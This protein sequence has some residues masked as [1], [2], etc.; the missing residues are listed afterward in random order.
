MTSTQVKTS[1]KKQGP[2]TGNKG[3]PSKREAFLNAKESSSSDKVYLAKNGKL[4]HLSHVVDLLPLKHS[5]LLKDFTLILTLVVD[6][7]KVM[8]VSLI[9]EHLAHLGKIGC[10]V[11]RLHQMHHLV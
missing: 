3:T 10:Q 5:L 1:I 6:L 11:E 8:V 4:M 2:R 9:K 7:L